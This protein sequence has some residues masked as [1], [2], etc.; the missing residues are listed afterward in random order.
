MTGPT[1]D[2]YDPP[3]DRVVPPRP[4]P[5]DLHT[6]TR[7][8]DGVLEPAIL[9]EAA[10]SAGVRLLAITDHDTLAG[11]R[12]VRR[13]ELPV[14]LELVAGVEINSIAEAIPDLWEGELHVLG[15]G[16]DPDDEGFE[17]ALAAQRGRRAT[18]FTRT[19]ARL[20][21]LGLPIDAQVAELAPGPDDAL[22]RPT[23]AR[24]LV[25]AGYASS[26]EDAF[27]RLVGRG[28]PAYVPRSG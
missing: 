26:V 2:R 24:C 15:Y 16:M 22:G 20:R 6:H 5:I 18:R 9:V 14:G 12:D 25:R 17:A 11:Y 19:V 8:S 21:E 27:R 13:A 4:S 23:I 28:Q 10:A 1:P 3:A 7:R